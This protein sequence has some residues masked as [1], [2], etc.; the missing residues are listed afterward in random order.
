MSAWRSKPKSHICNVDRNSLN[1]LSDQARDF[2]EEEESDRNAAVDGSGNDNPVEKQNVSR[3]H[4]ISDKISEDVKHNAR[5][6]SKDKEND[7]E[8]SEAVD[9]EMIIVET[10]PYTTEIV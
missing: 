2:T 10:V 4:I 6:V 3:I 9:E 8:K 5:D 7:E 1:Q